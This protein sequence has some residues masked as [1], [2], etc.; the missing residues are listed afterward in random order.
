[1]RVGKAEGGVA[2]EGDALAGGGYQG[3]LREGTRGSTL[4]VALAELRYQRCLREGTWEGHACRTTVGAR[5]TRLTRR[6][7]ESRLCDKA[8]CFGSGDGD[9]WLFGHDGQGWTGWHADRRRRCQKR[10][11]IEMPFRQIGE[12]PE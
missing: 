4:P 6:R 12:A 8:V 11:E 2:R 3:G 10:V 5:T 7:G 1:M 9:P